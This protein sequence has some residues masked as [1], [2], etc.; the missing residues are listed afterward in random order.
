M[1]NVLEHAVTRAFSIDGDAFWGV[2]RGAPDAAFA[3]QVGMYLAHVGFGLSLTEV[4]HLFARDRTTVAH[5]CTLV[6]DRRDDRCFDRA[7]ELLEGAVCLLRPSLAVTSTM[8]APSAVSLVG[9]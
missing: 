3:R 5:A 8:S 9:A 2:T 7:L 4:G 6:E 1:R